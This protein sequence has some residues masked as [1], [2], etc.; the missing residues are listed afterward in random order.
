MIARIDHVQLAA[1]TGCEAAARE[2]YG[3]IL[4]LREIEKPPALR[5]RGGC[6]FQCGDQ[7]IHIGVEAPFKPAKK[8]HPAFAVAD[9]G[10][11]RETLLARAVQITEDDSARH[12]PLFRRRSLGKPAGIP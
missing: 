1:P 9:L 3:S 12:A 6:W 10:K 4:G 7:Q 11:L 2:I 5:A 8:A